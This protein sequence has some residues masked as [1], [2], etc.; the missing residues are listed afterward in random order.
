L[1][2]AGQVVVVGSGDV[3]M[4]V[5]PLTI[6][7]L[8][9][10]TPILLVEREGDLALELYNYRGPQKRF[11]ELNWPGAFFRGRP[12]CGFYLEVSERRLYANGAAFGHVV[13][14]GLFREEIGAAFT[15][16][17]AGERRYAVAYCQDGQEL[18]IEIDLMQWRL[19]KRWNHNGELGWPMLES[20]AARQTQSGRVQVGNVTLSCDHGPIWLYAANGR[21]AAGYLGLEPATPTLLTP[22]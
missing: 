10:E 1:L 22:S 15:Y 7:P 14:A 3:Y 20:E 4:A 9:K 5:R 13:A 17:G 12:M 8:G 19:V 2:S 21:Q 11:W 6:T 18:G 16:A